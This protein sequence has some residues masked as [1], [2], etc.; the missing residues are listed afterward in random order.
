M[1]VLRK[2]LKSKTKTKKTVLSNDPWKKDSYKR[3]GMQKGANFCTT[4]LL[5]YHTSD[6]LD[7]LNQR[8]LP[9]LQVAAY[10]FILK[11]STISLSTK[12]LRSLNTTVIWKIENFYC[13]LFRTVVIGCNVFTQRKLPFKI[14]FKY[15]LFHK[16][17]FPWLLN[18]WKIN[19][20]NLGK[21]YCRR[22]L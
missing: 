3:Q 10:L 5:L 11:R 22:T 20:F 4:L 18:V 13:P 9:K 19:C 21:A 2:R 15:I 12:S 17:A 8:N 7:W 1:V 16:P 14:D 6:W